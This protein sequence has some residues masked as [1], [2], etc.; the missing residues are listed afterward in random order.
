MTTW[1]VAELDPIRRLRVM[2]AALPGSAIVEAQ[3][4]APFD[5]VWSQIEDMERWV[6]SFDPIV[7]AVE[8]L[9]RD[10][11]HLT[12]RS[13]PPIVPV[14]TRFDVELQPGWCWMRSRIYVV[15]MAAVADGDG[16]RYAHLEGVP[17]RWAPRRLVQPIARMTV[18]ADIH[19]I[20][21]NLGG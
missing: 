20:V 14:W 6:P 10:G 4:D 19:G 12:I 9:S 16:T 2:A 15:G 13:R 8:V 7:K 18:R 21:R 3:I 5:A 17:F 1:P 11:D